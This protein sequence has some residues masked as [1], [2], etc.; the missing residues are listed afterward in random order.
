MFLFNR[1]EKKY[2]RKSLQVLGRPLFKTNEVLLL[3][4]AVPLSGVS[5][6][7]V[8]DAAIGAGGYDPG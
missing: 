2:P 1:K 7:L 5:V 4:R 8:E 3:R 6:R